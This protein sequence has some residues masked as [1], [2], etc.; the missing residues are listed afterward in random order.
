MFILAVSTMLFKTGDTLLDDEDWSKPYLTR[1]EQIFVD[2]A[3]AKVAEF[4]ATKKEVE[5]QTDL[6]SAIRDAVNG[7][8]INAV[9][10]RWS[11]SADHVSYHCSDLSIISRLKCL[12]DLRGL[13]YDQ[14]MAHA[15]YKRFGITREGYGKISIGMNMRDVE[16]ILG[17]GEEQ[18][19]SG[20]YGHSA[21]M[22]RWQKGKAMITISF[23]DN[24]VSGRAQFGL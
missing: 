10:M 14:A 13:N 2:D 1:S 24:E 4:C 11:A 3:R 15:G 22:Y 7:R 9:V 20:G 6:E 21:A 12:S 23:R 5:C 19:Y 16:F 18:A 8:R 17:Q